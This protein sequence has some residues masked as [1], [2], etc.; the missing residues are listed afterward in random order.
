MNAEFSYSSVKPAFSGY[1]VLIQWAVS[2][3]GMMV[4]ASLKA[5]TDVHPFR[6]YRTGQSGQRMHVSMSCGEHD[7]SIRPLG[8]WEAM[9]S[10]WSDDPRSGMKV[11]IRLDD[12][13]DGAV[14]HPLE[15]MQKGDELFIVCWLINDE[16]SVVDET[17]INKPRKTWDT[18]RP[19][20]Q[21]H[22]LCRDERFQEWCAVEASKMNIPENNNP[23]D[24]CISVIR[25]RCGII[26]RKEFSEDSEKGLYARKKW[27][28]MVSEYRNWS[29]A[30]A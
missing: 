17:N 19:A 12:G 11:H 14:Q 5:D 16:E 3:D 9:L 22:T 20:Q 2:N 4:K 10:W 23:E 8:A 24:T 26:S 1:A 21:A 28:S 30:A 27:I 15:G 7:G 18:L 13:P 25:A 6:N 29:S